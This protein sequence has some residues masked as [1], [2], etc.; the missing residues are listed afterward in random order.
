MRQALALLMVGALLALSTPAAHA[1]TPAVSGEVTQKLSAAATDPA[2]AVDGWAYSVPSQFWSQ[3][4]V[5]DRV[6]FDG[7]QW[8]I[9]VPYRWYE[10]NL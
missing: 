6:L 8:K 9:V 5:G 7:A 1:G 2:I 4:T 3:V 10:H